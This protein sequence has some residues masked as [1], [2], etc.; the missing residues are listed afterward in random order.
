MTSTGDAVPT[1]S[2]K[3]PPSAVDDK[4]PSRLRQTVKGVL[5]AVLVVAIFYFLFRKIDFSTVWAEIRGLTWLE[6]STLLVLAGW[7]LLTYAFVWMSVTVPRLSFGRAMLMTQSTTAVANTVYGGAAIGIGMTYSMFSGWGYSR[8]RTT[9]AVLVSGVWNSFIKLGLPVL[10]LALVA[11]Q[12]GVGGGRVTAAL[13]GLSGLVAA[14]VVFALILRSERTAR[15][16]GL[17]AAGVA[18]RIVRLA[19]RPPVHGWELATVKFRGRT[20]ELVRRRWIP[21]TATSLVSH[22]SLYLVLLVAL[23]HMGVSDAEVSWAEVLAVFAFARLATAV[24]F[25]PGGA[26]VVEAVLIGGLD[27]AGGDR[28]EVTAA[29]L[30][31]RALTWGLPILVGIVSFLWWRRRSAASGSSTGTRLGEE[32]QPTAA[33]RP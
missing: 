21:I 14:I 28:A 5:S 4:R 16:V 32:T 30:I 9:T 26:G 3:Q 25:T 19:G 17:R 8:S 2:G 27:A 15:L 6:L 12:G 31:Y 33:G 13:I 1:T 29:V 22:L 11:L 18:S 23:R 7:N 24:P 20:V 10:A